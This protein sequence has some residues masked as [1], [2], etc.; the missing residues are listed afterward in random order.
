[1]V[2]TEIKVGDL[3]TCDSGHGLSFHNCKVVDI[4][5]NGYI[6]A[7]LS[8][9]IRCVIARKHQVELENV[10]DKEEIDDTNN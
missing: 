2:E 4:L 7:E 5:D 8:E 3:V 10:K 6:K 9:P 1:M